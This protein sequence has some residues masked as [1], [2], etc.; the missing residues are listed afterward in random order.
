MD[1]RRKLNG[2][3]EYAVTDVWF[4][5]RAG[6]EYLQATFV[7]GVVQQNRREIER[8]LDIDIIM[9]RVCGL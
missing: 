8:N 5:A 3:D 7:N 6:V 4:S 1:H 2:L 9:V